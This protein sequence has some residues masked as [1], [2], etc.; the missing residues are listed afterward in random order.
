M[1]PL[2][3]T[4][5]DS[6]GPYRLAARLGAGGMGVVYLGHSPGGR[7][8][9]V[10]V[11]RERFHSDF[12]FRARFRREVAA[13]RTVTGAFTASVLDADPEAAAPWLV[14]AYLP[15][16]SLREAVRAEG[17]L[18]PA[19][20]RLLAAGL[21]EALA[22]IHR[23]GLT[24]RDLKPGNVMLTADGPRVI[25][26]GIAR[27]E[28]ATA[29]TQVG[30]II[31][32]PGFMS[33]EQVSGGV[34][35]PRSDIFS[36]GAVLAYAATG[37][38]PFGSDATLATLYRV[39]TAQADLDG[40]PDP[41][42]LDLITTCLRVVP[43]QRPSAAQLLDRLG[44]MAR[45]VAGTGWLPA[46]LAEEIDRRTAQARHLPRSPTAGATAST[47]SPTA[48]PAPPGEDPLAPGGSTSAPGESRPDPAGNPSDLAGNP[49]GLAEKTRDPTGHAWAPDANTRAPGATTLDPGHG[50][51]EP[52]KAVPAAAGPV[53]G[54]EIGWP[55]VGTAEPAKHGTPAGNRRLD[56]RY[57]LGGAV[58]A[59]AVATGAGFLIR[60]RS[61]DRAAPT[62]T[63]TPS[64]APPTPTA[65]P[66]TAVPRWRAKVSAYYPELFTAG[67]V[68]LAK[69][70]EQEL[71]A[72][73]AR[74]GRTRW[75]HP[76][77]LTGTVAGGLVLEAQ[78]TNPRLTSVDPVSGT[79][80]WR[81]RVRF[82]EFPLWPVV[83]GSVLCCGRDPIRGLGVRDGR[84]RWAARIGE[85]NNLAAGD[86]VVVAAND[87]ELIALAATTGRTRWRCPMDYAFYLLV[88]EGLVFAVDR[89]RALHA[90]RADTGAT[91]W[92]I[93]TF[94]GSSPPQLGGGTLYATGGRGE[95]FALTAA[96][97]EP[98]WSRSLDADSAV[99]LS[100]DTLYAASTD[101]MLYALD[102]A[103]GRLRWT[104]EASIVQPPVLSNAGLVG[105]GGLVFVGTREGY[106]EALA[107]PT[108]VAGATA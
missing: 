83:T 100:G 71:Y 29:I 49:S 85:I 46:S 35:E 58:G 3:P 99:R 62:G 17:H 98:R 87:T 19:A 56:R 91:A 27:P 39:Q 76:A 108:G 1:K 14:T 74:T 52:G 105:M 18:P 7:A 68:V 82:G 78:N 102:A 38:E 103:D 92:R 67:G 64:S 43:G 31:G 80:R 42:M 12:E 79:T 21:A 4:D 26:F 63:P 81:Y 30:S 77:T 94:G 34:T 23:V 8:V 22:D 36:L 6:V 61:S 33:P 106:V 9:A 86:G 72:L 70:Q 69:T 95:V 37:R 47:P 73:N 16:L 45:A 20:V 104:Y 50:T 93:A 107:P 51:R 59:L 84:E 25:D 24:H 65:A 44:A 54:A 89:N 75:K 55:A 5:P 101:G 11:V 32:T 57:L 97:G 28:D 41:W 13:A 53:P 10:K 15:G 60:G 48:M 90:L 2:L 96:T 66:P 40:I 88:G